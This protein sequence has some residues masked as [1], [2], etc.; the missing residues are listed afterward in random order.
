MPRGN[1]KYLACNHESCRCI[2]HGRRSRRARTHAVVASDVRER[3]QTGATISS[4]AK[5]YGVSYETVRSRLTGITRH[6]G[7]NRGSDTSTARSIL[8]RRRAEGLSIAELD[9]QEYLDRSY[10]YRITRKDFSG[11]ENWF[12]QEGAA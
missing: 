2:S 3:H 6:R 4:L 11:V 12:K 8:V 5:E 9:R 10:V 7:R 1:R